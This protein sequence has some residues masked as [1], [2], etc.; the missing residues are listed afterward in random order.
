MIRSDAIQ[1][2][3]PA[4]TRG[5]AR[6]PRFAVGRRDEIDRSVG[7]RAQPVLAG[8]LA[9]SSLAL[10]GCSGGG[11]VDSNDVGQ[12]DEADSLAGLYG[13]DY[14][15][16]RPSPTHLR[17]EGYRFAVRYFSYDSGKN[18]TAS[19]AQALEA[20]GLDV[21]SNWEAGNEDALDGYARGVEHAWHD[22]DAYRPVPP[23]RPP[24]VR[25]I[26]ASTSTRRRINRARSTTIWTASLR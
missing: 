2:R 18:L 20:A 10:F 24:I 13:C 12:G 16:A 11:A 26:S 5:R 14:S 23:A 6:G 22:A 3:N 1:T 21:V 9:F 7:P 17:S 15:F 4:R 19:E 25:S 8:F